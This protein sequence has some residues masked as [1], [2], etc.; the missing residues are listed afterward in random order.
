M[1]F[2]ADLVAKLPAG[3]GTHGPDYRIRKRYPQIRLLRLCDF[4][5]R[6]VPRPRR[7]L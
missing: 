6:G 2:M 1:K 7:T 4:T 5:G 3:V